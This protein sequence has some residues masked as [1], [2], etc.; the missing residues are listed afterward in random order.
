MKASVL[1]KTSSCVH[2]RAKRQGGAPC[3]P[4]GEGAA[5]DD[6]APRSTSTAGLL[7]FMAI[8]FS[9]LCVTIKE[10]EKE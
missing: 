9:A 4:F 5:Q 6:A 7:S 10:A 3:P 1:C 2:F 8:S